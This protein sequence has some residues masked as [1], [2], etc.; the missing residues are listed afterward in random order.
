MNV[1]LERFVLASL[2]AGFIAVALTNPMHFDA[3]P[4]V[5]LGIVILVLAAFAA[6]ALN[7]TRTAE[8][9]ANTPPNEAAAVHPKAPESTRN[10]DEKQDRVF[11]G[12]NITPKYLI[13]IF[14]EHT[15][16]QGAALTSAYLGKWMKVSGSLGNVISTS[17]YRAQLTFER[18]EVPLTERTWFDY[19]DFFMMF[20]KPWIDRLAIAR[21]GDR[22]TVIGQIERI[23]GV[24]VQLDSCELVGSGSK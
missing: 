3:V 21:R 11:V 6:Y 19:T 18:A 5:T 22:L 23:D 14:R 1:F 12:E 15:D 20:R 24:S 13:G 16:I 10:Q 9:T 8:K 7:K 4:R 2:A 17:P